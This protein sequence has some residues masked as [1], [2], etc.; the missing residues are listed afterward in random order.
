[1]SRRLNELA[2]NGGAEPGDRGMRENPGN[3]RGG[4]PGRPGGNAEMPRAEK[5]E[6]VEIAI[7]HLRSAGLHDVAE[8]LAR[9]LRERLQDQRNGMGPGAGD[10]GPR[11]PQGPRQ[12]QLRPPDRDVQRPDG[13]RAE[14]GR[15][16]GGPNPNSP[17]IQDQLND[18]RRQMEELRRRLEDGDRDHR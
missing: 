12:Q 11:G 10:R 5:I 14:P 4:E 13:D 16:N 6:H 18:L 7:R 15:R 9:E 1:M 17:G 3:R 2:R 8:R